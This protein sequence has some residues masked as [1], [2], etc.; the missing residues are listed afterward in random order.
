[1]SGVLC[2]IRQMNRKREL[3]VADFS[4]LAILLMIIIGAI[5]SWKCEDNVHVKLARLAAS[6]CSAQFNDMRLVCTL[7]QSNRP[8]AVREK[9]RQFGRQPEVKFPIRSHDDE[10]RWG[11][12]TGLC[13]V[14]LADC[15]RSSTAIQLTSLPKLPSA[16]QNTCSEAA[17]GNRT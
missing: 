11:R 3:F 4:E 1:M 12:G 5:K 14:N 9:Q 13:L 10:C 15:I 8:S 2:Y 6:S 16:M 17:A 7:L